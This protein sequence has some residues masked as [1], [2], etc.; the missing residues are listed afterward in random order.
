V[1]SGCHLSGFLDIFLDFLL[2]FEFFVG[3][4]RVFSGF[5]EILMRVFVGFEECFAIVSSGG[6]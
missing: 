2:L 6:K 1:E 5:Q 4:M 3:F